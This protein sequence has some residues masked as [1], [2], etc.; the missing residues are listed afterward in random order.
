MAGL[1]F[2]Q[3]LFTVRQRLRAM[4]PVSDHQDWIRKQIECLP[5]SYLRPGKEQQVL[6]ELTKLAQLPRGQ[7]LAWGRFLPSQ[8]AVEYTIGTTD[9]AVPGIFHRLTGVLTSTGHS[10][11]SA[12]IHTLADQLVLDRFYVQDLDFAGEP[13]AERIKE[14]CQKLID[15]ICKPTEGRPTFRRVW[16]SSQNLSALPVL[17]ERVH[18]DNATSD[19]HTIIT[20]FAYDRMGLLYEI[21]RT[22][23]ELGLS[24]HVAKVGTYLDQVVDVFYVTDQKGQKIQDEAR[25]EQ[26]RTTLLEALAAHARQEGLAGTETLQLAKPP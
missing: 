24:V 8:Q 15:A 18:W 2:R 22:L 25:L 5:A 1:G 3:R 14:V 26:I 7:A 16:R 9:D 17:P 10:I 12:E 20:V 19:R 11:L 6:E 23:F 21:T 4:V 13:P